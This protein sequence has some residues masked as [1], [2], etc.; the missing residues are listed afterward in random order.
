MTDPKNTFSVSQT[1]YDLIYEAQG[2]DY[3]DEVRRLRSLLHDRGIDATALGRPP[4][5]LDVACGT[6]QHL[7]RL[8][9][10]ERVGVDVDPSMLEIASHRCPDATLVEGDM[11]TLDPLSLIHI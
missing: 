2:K 6:G 1:W 10:F 3:A 5:M 9:D 4:R 11:R 8:D 7:A